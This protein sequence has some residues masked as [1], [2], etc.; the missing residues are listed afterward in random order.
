MNIRTKNWVTTGLHLVAMALF[1]WALYFP[2]EHD[3][4]TLRAL[5]VYS[6][7]GVWVFYLFVRP[8]LERRKLAKTPRLVR[9]KP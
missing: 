2:V 5:Q 9:T 7:T 1:I 8:W 6:G 4:W 3:H